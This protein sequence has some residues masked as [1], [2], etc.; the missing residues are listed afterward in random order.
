MEPISQMITISIPDYSKRIEEERTKNRPANELFVRYPQW[1]RELYL[2]DR[3]ELLKTG[4][5]LVVDPTGA[6][7]PEEFI[8]LM[9]RLLDG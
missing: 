4:K 1:I 3:A 9:N 6:F 5:L 7:T 2:R 8:D